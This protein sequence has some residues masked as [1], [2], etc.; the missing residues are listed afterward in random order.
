MTTNAPPGSPGSHAPT[1]RDL[2]R[3]AA[4]VGAA[5]WTAPLI[6]GSVASPAGAA[7]PCDCATGSAYTG[8]KLEG[9]S[10]SSGTCVSS[11]AIVTGASGFT[12][13]GNRC[14]TNCWASVN[15][16]PA[17]TG[18]VPTYDCATFTVRLPDG[19]TWGAKGMVAVF[20][21]GPPTCAGNYYVETTLPTGY[22]CSLPG[23]TT[24]NGPNV[25]APTSGLTATGSTFVIPS[26]HRAKL[27]HVNLIYCCC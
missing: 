11:S 14:G 3:R 2:I 10:S 23:G 24:N 7:T 26:A 25:A 9:I 27:S 6:V 1:R 12:S 13:T 18:P 4:I 21:G 15:G 5:A 8:A 19:C 20:V 16:S 22:G 17:G